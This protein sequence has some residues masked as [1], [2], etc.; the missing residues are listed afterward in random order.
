[1]R[2]ALLILAAVLLLAGGGIQ[3]QRSLLD[4]K[5][6]ER[7]MQERKTAKRLEKATFAAG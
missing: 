2:P 3:C 6:K 4:S 5:Q 1:M 7:M